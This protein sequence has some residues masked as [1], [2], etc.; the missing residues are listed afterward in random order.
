ML[1]QIPHFVVCLTSLT[2]FCYW[3]KLNM[4]MAPERWSWSCPV[5]NPSFWL[6]FTLRSIFCF[7]FPSSAALCGIYICHCR[8]TG[9]SERGHSERGEIHLT[10]IQSPLGWSFCIIS[11]LDRGGKYFSNINDYCRPIGSEDISRSFQNLSYSAWSA[12]V[13]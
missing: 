6:S 9:M 4:C 2:C 11:A 7:I 3:R 8:P 5:V 1:C 12:C 10:L 13:T